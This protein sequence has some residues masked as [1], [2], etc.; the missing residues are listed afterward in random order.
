MR[1]SRLNTLHGRVRGQRAGIVGSWRE[2]PGSAAAFKAGSAKHPCVHEIRVST[3]DS[4]C[5][6][7][8]VKQIMSAGG[9]GETPLS[10]SRQRKLQQAVDSLLES[11]TKL[12]YGANLVALTSS[13]TLPPRQKNKNKKRVKYI[14]QNC[15]F[16]SI[17]GLQTVKFKLSNGSG[18]HK[19][20]VMVLGNGVIIVIQDKDAYCH[21]RGM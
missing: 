9:S 10:C 11:V 14:L 20:G 15:V 2:R 18:C 4:C 8:T 12:F 7:V 6:V 5:W 3:S 17:P 21:R 19:E 1:V 16:P 13:L